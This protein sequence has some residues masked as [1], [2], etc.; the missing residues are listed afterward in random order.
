[1]KGEGEHVR[2]D[3]DKLWDDTKWLEAQGASTGPQPFV[4]RHAEDTAAQS[5]SCRHQL[6]APAVV[7]ANKEVSVKHPEGKK[8]R[9]PVK[10]TQPTAQMKCLYVNTRSMG[11]K[12]EKL[13]VTVLLE[14]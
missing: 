13:E 12:Q 3:G 1:M 11:N 6:G 4:K 7:G 2:L 8:G 14:S 9:Y 10:A 5:K